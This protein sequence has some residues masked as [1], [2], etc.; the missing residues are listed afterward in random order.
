MVFSVSKIVIFGSARG[1]GDTKAAVLQVLHGIAYDFIDLATLQISAYDYEHKNQNDDFLP[2][3]EKMVTY[4]DIILATPVYWYAASAQMKT[5][6]D[7]WSDLLSIR[8][9]LGR[10][11][12]GKNLFVISS[13]SADS[14]A[15]R[16]SFETPI[17]MTCAYMNMVYGGCF[18]AL[19]EKNA[20]G[21]TS[22]DK[23]RERDA[24]RKKLF[25]TSN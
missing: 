5:F 19:P 14:Q 3:V 18:Y 7:R 4:D 10:K 21:N 20:S 15:S 2:L 13:Y 16:V 12:A 22:E 1:D 11:L 8:K 6:I 25:T 24:F 17:Q 9:E 23:N